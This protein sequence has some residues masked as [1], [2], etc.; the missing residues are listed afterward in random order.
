MKN[1]KITV[2]SL[3]DG[4]SGGQQALERIKWITVDKYLASEVNKYAIAITKYN[5]P[6]TI[7]IGDVKEINIEKLPHIDLLIGGSPCQGFS[8]SGK[9]VG[10]STKCKI[11]ITSLEQYLKLKKEN[12]EFEGQ[13]Y[14]FWEYIRIYRDLKKINPNIKFLLENVQMEKKWKEMFDKAIGVKPIM[15]DSKLLSAQQR[16][17]Y[18]WTNLSDNIEQPKDLNIELKDILED[19]PF[20]NNG[21]IY[22]PQELNKA[23]ILG[24]RLNKY[25]KRD[26]YNKD[27]PIIQCLEVRDVNRNKSNCITTVAKDNVLT[28]LEIGRHPDVYGKNLPYR[29]YTNIEKERLQTI[30]DDFTKYGIDEK[31]NIIEISNS[32]RN[33]AIGN[34]WTI[35]VIKYLLE[36]ILKD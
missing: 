16:K 24:R 28:P 32:Q 3:F 2:L 14:L 19:I 12:F 34:G 35:E 11:E 25:G 10:A 13:S 17:R 7:F 30:K 5:Y 4:I 9:R 23:T 20:E 26:D 21:K 22:K 33:H 15:I 8:F 18:Y 29:N 31:G 1:K 6:N 36:K 27:I